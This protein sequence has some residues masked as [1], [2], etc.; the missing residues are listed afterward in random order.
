VWAHYSSRCTE[1]CEGTLLAPLHG[2]MCGHTTRPSAR[3]YVWAHYSP[4]CTELCEGTL[5]APL[6]GIM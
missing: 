4:L 6:H 2:I 5:L 3:N 1:L